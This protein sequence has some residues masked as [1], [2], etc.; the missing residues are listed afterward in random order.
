M[1][2]V[3]AHFIPYSV[4]EILAQGVWS[5]AKAQAPPAGAT[6]ETG[7]RP[8]EEQ[9]KVQDG[10]ESPSGKRRRSSRNDF[11]VPDHLQAIFARC[12]P[13]Q[14]SQTQ[15][16]HT[17]C[18]LHVDDG[19]VH[20]R[21]LLSRA[22]AAAGA[23]VAVAA[24]I[25]VRV[26]AMA[27]AAAA[28]WHE[29]PVD[30]SKAASSLY[31]YLE[32]QRRLY[33]RHAPWRGVNLGGW[34]LLEPGPSADLFERCPGARS[35]WS[36]MRKMRE[37]LG[38]DGAAEVLRHHRETF[39]TEE[40]IRRIKAL[41]MNAVRIPF[42]YWV[43][44]GPANEDEFVG[45][46]VEYLDRAVEWCKIHGLQ[47]LLDLH[48]APGGESGEKP[49]GR[50]C[51]DWQWKDWRVD[52]SLDILR[53]VAQRYAGNE[54]VT[55]IAVCNEP[56]E[57]IPAEVLC[58]FYDRAVRTIREAGMSPDQVSVILPIYRTERLD[59]IWRLWNG[60][61]DGFLQHANVAFDL[62]LYHV[63]GP[64]W[65]RQGLGSHLR[66]AKRHRKILRRIPAVVGEWSLALPPQA[67]G[68]GDVD[69]NEAMRTF[70]GGQLEAY[71]QATHGWFY[72]NWRDSPQEH[73]GWDVQQSIERQWLT[74]GGFAGPVSSVKLGS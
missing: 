4:C 23:D 22:L 24:E 65:Q 46:C 47:V 11:A 36:L 17:N 39:I 34:L 40:D 15:D 49:C 5:H 2:T 48:G 26:R 68:D 7:A 57:T 60:T 59:E 19:F 53:T 67:L 3:P 44:T 41:G 61:Y 31:R 72:W 14:P 16:D 33:W 51:K 74:K 18:T 63:F 29:A 56:S 27:L 73:A 8:R 20:A 58:D 70:A 52:E 43:I 71:S 62:H 54:V 35:E 64:W 1:D 45:P 32:H 42:G 25:V 10:S 66:M 13:T 12:G 38:A 21:G 6:S 9:K 55:G 50:E 69:E 28:Y 30:L 37:T